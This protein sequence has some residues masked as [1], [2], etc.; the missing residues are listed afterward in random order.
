MKWNG[1]TQLALLKNAALKRE[2]NEMHRR[3]ND[4]YKIKLRMK[5]NL[6]MKKEETYRKKVMENVAKILVSMSSDSAISEVKEW[7]NK[8]N[9]L[10]KP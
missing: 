10:L 6:D 1:Q 8:L 5:H 7:G 3:I 9:K 2:L 4:L